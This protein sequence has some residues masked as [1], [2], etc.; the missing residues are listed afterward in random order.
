MTNLDEIYK[1]MEQERFQKTEN[2]RRYATE[3]D[4]RR[5]EFV[6]AEQRLYEKFVIIT[7]SDAVS[8]GGGS[9]NDVNCG[10][11]QFNLNK[12]IIVEYNEDFNLGTND[13]TIEWFQFQLSGSSFPRTFQFGSWPSKLGVS[14]EPS[15]DIFV[16]YFWID[17]GLGEGEYIAALMTSPLD[18]WVHF[19]ISRLNG[20]TRIYINGIKMRESSLEYSID[21]TDIPMQIGVDIFYT[22]STYFNGGISN[23]RFINGTGLYQGDTITVPISVLQPIENTKLLLQV[24]TSDTFLVNSGVS[25]IITN[26]NSNW[27]PGN[28]FKN[29]PLVV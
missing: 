17:Q 5:R 15:G 12:Y 8:A 18:K 22:G 27:N 4:K 19:A 2:E 20:T 10:C 29:T 1:R 11:I 21:V 23:F 7:N 24:R 13:F 28:P 14:I 9:G 3:S 26:N 16:L 25:K 6:L